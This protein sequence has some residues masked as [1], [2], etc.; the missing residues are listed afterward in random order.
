MTHTAAPA[1]PHRI[2][3]VDPGLAVCGYGVVESDGPDLRAV[4]FGT[5][6]TTSDREL[7]E[8]ITAIYNAF[9]E[10]VERHKP[11]ACAIESLFFHR[12]AKVAFQVGHVRGALILGAALRGVPVFEYTPLRIKQSVVGYGQAE[13]H[14]VQYMMKMILNMPKPP[15]PADAADALAVAVTHANTMRMERMTGPMVRQ[16]GATR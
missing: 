12:N 11:D 3:G 15:T 14:Q 7:P 4:D 8:R 5:I 1:T 6:K 16:G 9:V 2:L 10:V 13:K